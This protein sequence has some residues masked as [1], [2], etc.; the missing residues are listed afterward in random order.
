MILFW[1]NAL[2]HSEF[3][4]ILWI[5]VFQMKFK[6]MILRFINFESF[7]QIWIFEGPRTDVFEAAIGRPWIEPND[8]VFTLKLIFGLAQNGFDFDPKD[9]NVDFAK[10]NTLFRSTFTEKTRSFRKVA[11]HFFVFLQW[12][13][14]SKCVLLRQNANFPCVV[15]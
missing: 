4:M 9:Q 3:P 10:G 15:F 12:K 13:W 14:P 8:A 11:K 7:W 6:N 5:F 2:F 1:R